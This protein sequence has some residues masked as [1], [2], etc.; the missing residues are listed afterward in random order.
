MARKKQVWIIRQQKALKHTFSWKTT[1]QLEHITKS[2]YSLCLEK[3]CCCHI[4]RNMKAQNCNWVTISSYNRCPKCC[5]SNY[6]TEFNTVNLL[7]TNLI[8]YKRN[9]CVHYSARLFWI[10]YRQIIRFI[11]RNFVCSYWISLFFLTTS[12]PPILSKCLYC[13]AC[14]VLQAQNTFIF[15]TV[16]SCAPSFTLERRTINQI[17]QPWIFLCFIWR[18]SNS[19]KE[20]IL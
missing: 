5:H 20:Y 2:D 10:S 1:L 7:I 6:L 12:F 18:E 4:T 9:I 19:I 17:Y 13:Y 8:L 11:Q 14:N 3:C 16:I 15:S